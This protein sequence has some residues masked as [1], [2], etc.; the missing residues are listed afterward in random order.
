[1]KIQPPHKLIPAI[2]LLSLSTLTAGLALTAAL[3]AAAQSPLATTDQ[4]ALDR[5][6]LRLLA[7]QPVKAEVALVTQ[8]F[9]ADPYAVLRREKESCSMRWTR[10][11]MPAWSTPS[12]AIPR[13]PSAMAVGA[14]PHL[15]RDCGADQ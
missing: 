1:M 9:A 15:V 5:Q 7:S 12:I 2:L 11:S 10:W 6:S 14:R 8:S 13:V 3:V 4:K